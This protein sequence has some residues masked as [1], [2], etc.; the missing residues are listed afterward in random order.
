MVNTTKLK[1]EIEQ[2]ILSNGVVVVAALEIVT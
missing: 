2:G 1:H